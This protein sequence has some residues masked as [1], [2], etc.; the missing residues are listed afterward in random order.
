MKLQGNKIIVDKEEFLV[1]SLTTGILC[2]WLETKTG[3]PMMEWANEA[4]QLAEKQYDQMN[5]KQRD[6]FLNAQVEIAKTV[7]P[8]E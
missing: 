5:Q 3:I 2:Q 7:N 1:N 8:D 6:D 4:G